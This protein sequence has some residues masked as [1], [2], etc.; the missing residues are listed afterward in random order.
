M[1]VG[2]APL[3]IGIPGIVVPVPPPLG[4]DPLGE[5]LDVLDQ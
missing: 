3:A 2:V 4:D 1:R 5:A